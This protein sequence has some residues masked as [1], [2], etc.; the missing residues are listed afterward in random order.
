MEQYLK[1]KINNCVNFI[2]NKI[3]I[4]ENYEIIEKQRKI[5]YYS[6]YSLEINEFLL[7]FS[8]VKTSN[9]IFLKIYYRKYNLVQMEKY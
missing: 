2:K 4:G 7:I 9:K 6:K 5:F 1:Q 8:M 3:N